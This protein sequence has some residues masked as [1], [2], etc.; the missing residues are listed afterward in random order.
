MKVLKMSSINYARTKIIVFG[1]QSSAFR[2]TILSDLGILW[3]MGCFSIILQLIN[4]SL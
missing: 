2:W 3:G 4:S 1:T